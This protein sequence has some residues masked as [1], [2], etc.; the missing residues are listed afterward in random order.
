MSFKDDV[1]ADLDV[2]LNTAEFGEMHTIDGKPV[3]CIIKNSL[4][5]A[6]DDEIG[7]LAYSQEL[8]VH[9]RAVDLAKMPKA[10]LALVLDGT[11][12]KVI[13]VPEAGGMLAIRL[14]ANR[15]SEWD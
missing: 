10:G 13:D 5:S 6:N 7:A 11:P 15:P 3:V 4:A 9:V 14:D 8:T 12:Y 1:A 2:F